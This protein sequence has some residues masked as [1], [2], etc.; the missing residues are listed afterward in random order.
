[1]CGV[2]AYYAYHRAAP[3][4]QRAAVA[5]VLRALRVRG[6]DGEGEW[7][8][9]DGR[10]ALAHTR[11]AIIGPGSQGHQP[12]VNAQQTQVLSFNGAI[13]NHAQ[14]RTALELRGHQFNGDSDTEVLLA[15]YCE[16]GEA[17]LMQLR[18]MFAF[19]LWDSARDELI[20]AR[21][22]YGIKPLYY[23]DDGRT[24][25]VA[26]QVAA[27]RSATIPMPLVGRGSICL[28]VSP[29]RSRP[30][31]LF[32]RFL[33]VRWCELARTVRYRRRSGSILR[34]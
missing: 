27:R 33:P 2:L 29:N 25:R 10:V 34:L 32:V 24:A 6:P 1:V 31:E 13:Y 11:L 3:A 7:F 19:A 5:H 8:S 14:L 21:D 16:H 12:M 23:A 22:A 28:A 18:G 17:M 30:I 4:L 9:D 20:L 26:S 15:M